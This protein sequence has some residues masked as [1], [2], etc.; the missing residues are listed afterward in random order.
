MATDLVNSQGKQRLENLRDRTRVEQLFDKL[1]EHQFEYFYE[2][3]YAGTLKY[4]MFFHPNSIRQMKAHPDIL[5]LDCTYSTNQYNLPL[6]NIVGVS[7]QNTTIQV[8]IALLSGKY[9]NIIYQFEA[10]KYF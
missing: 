1:N 2:K 9:R 10:N 6:L 7:A 5:G 3:D 4:L 8:G